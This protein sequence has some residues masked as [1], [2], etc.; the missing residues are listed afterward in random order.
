MKKNL[1]FSFL[2]I[3]A[4]LILLPFKTARAL[5]VNP[6]VVVDKS[7]SHSEKI[8][9]FSVLDIEVPKL[10]GNPTSKV[11]SPLNN[12]SIVNNETSTGMQAIFNSAFLNVRGLT[13]DFAPTPIPTSVLLL[14]S[15]L[16]GLIG[17]ARRSLF[18]K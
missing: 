14:G 15:G 6:P 2:L 5:V 10:E 9:S 17:I 1:R 7:E 3:T 16:I 12:L 4:L 8:G 11:N 13:D 18:T